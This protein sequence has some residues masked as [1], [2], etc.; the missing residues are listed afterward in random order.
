MFGDYIELVVNIWRGALAIHRKCGLLKKKIEAR[1]K[2]CASAWG[3]RTGMW[4]QNISADKDNNF[5]WN[6]LCQTCWVKPVW[7][8]FVVVHSPFASW[9]ESVSVWEVFR[10]IQE[11]PESLHWSL[12]N[13][14]DTTEGRS[15]IA[16][17]HKPP[18]KRETSILINFI[19]NRRRH[20][21]SEETQPVPV[22]GQTGF[23]S[24]AWLRCCL[25]PGTFI[26]VNWF[27]SIS[28]PSALTTSQSA[29]QP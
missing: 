10:D 19:T 12:Y 4:G 11:F 29:I 15:Q 5:H 9:G 7:E 24:P 27:R 25:Q 21:K 1:V 6:G 3:R 20:I 26:S 2:I 18:L 16:P 8:T 22:P 17:A 28:G 13:P 14:H 23:T